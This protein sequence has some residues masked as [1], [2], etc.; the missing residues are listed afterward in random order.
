[1]I[2]LSN[3]VRVY[4]L[5]GKENDY[6]SGTKMWVKSG[7]NNMQVVIHIDGKSATIIGADLIAAIRNATNVNQ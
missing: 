7:D 5:N 2:T 3:Q 6:M 1:M 4:V